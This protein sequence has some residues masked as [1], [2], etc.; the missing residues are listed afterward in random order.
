[1]RLRIVRSG[2]RWKHDKQVYAV[3]TEVIRDEDPDLSINVE[4]SLLSL[5]YLKAL[6]PV[7]KN[8]VL[9]T[10]IQIH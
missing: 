9:Q 4:S 6:I 1:M 10:C 5:K 8:K 2:K 7:I 3:I